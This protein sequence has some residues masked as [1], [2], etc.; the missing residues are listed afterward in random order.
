MQTVYLE[1]TVI[2]H[3]AG[4]L[5]PAASILARQQVTREWLAT[6]ASRYLLFVS[7]LALA[8]AATQES[9]LP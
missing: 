4:R 8:D 6:A 2:G 9:N 5:H 7:D 1:T 3:V